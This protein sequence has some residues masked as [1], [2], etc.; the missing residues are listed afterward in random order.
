MRMHPRPVVS[1]QPKPAVQPHW[2][3]YPTITLDFAYKSSFSL[4]HYV[5]SLRPAHVQSL[6]P[7]RTA[8][9]FFTDANW[10]TGAS[11]SAAARLTA[12]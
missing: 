3:E 5:Q 11:L 2:S 8:E 6:R 1:D 4:N 7:R 12:P 9:Y 10:N